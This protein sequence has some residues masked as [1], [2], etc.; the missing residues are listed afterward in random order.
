[1]GGCD[2]GLGC[3]VGLGGVVGGCG[4]GWRCCGGLRY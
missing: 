3:C 2:G 4:G 1:M